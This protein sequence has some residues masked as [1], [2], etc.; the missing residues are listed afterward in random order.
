[1]E[2][3][4]IAV[5]LAFIALVLSSTIQE[6]AQITEMRKLAWKLNCTEPVCVVSKGQ[7]GVW[8]DKGLLAKTKYEVL[9][10]TVEEALAYLLVTDDAEVRAKF[11][12]QIDEKISEINFDETPSDEL[13]L[14]ANELRYRAEHFPSEYREKFN[15]TKNWL[16]ENGT[17]NFLFVYSHH[18]LD[19]KPKNISRTNLSEASLLM[20][21]IFSAPVNYE[22][23]GPNME[24]TFLMKVV[25]NQIQKETDERK[26]AEQL[27][28]LSLYYV[29]TYPALMVKDSIFSMMAMYAL[30]LALICW[31]S[32]LSY[33]TS[34]GESKSSK[35]QKEYSKKVIL[36]ALLAFLLFPLL[37][38]LSLL[39]PLFPAA[40]YII[41]ILP[42]LLP[43]ISFI[44]SSGMMLKDYGIVK[45][46]LEKFMLA[47]YKEF[48]LVVLASALVTLI[49]IFVILNLQKIFWYMSMSVVSALGVL[50]LFVFL[51]V[52]V[53]AFFPRFVEFISKSSETRSA[54]VRRRIEELA[55]KF[56]YN[57][58]SI[59]ILPSSGSNLANAFQSG[60]IGKNIKIF[61][62]ET[63]LDRRKFKQ[64]EL[65]AIVAHEL[66]HINK[67]HVVKTVF[68]YLVIASSVIALF[69][70]F[71]L[72]V[73]AAN[74]TAL[75]ELLALGGPYIALV[76]A[77]LAT[78]RM[79]RG[80]EFEADSTAAEMGY[81]K[82]LISAL[83]KIDRYNLTPRRVS[84][85]IT[86]FSSHADLGSRIRNLKKIQLKQ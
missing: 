66:A 63:M 86:L 62:F 3:L 35:F 42:I 27:C 36:T 45:K 2:K 24:H 5:A 19:I 32:V 71:S 26:L 44:W 54:K 74:L 70:I 41:F 75:R 61:I 85:F 48:F 22:L 17:R 49:S 6:P 80:F 11:K 59:R 76:I 50:F 4:Q 28:S 69:I 79:M 67:K 31:M 57:V 38:Q 47:R 34:K 14:L 40:I 55:G 10:G 65:E 20:L 7:I 73:E 15:Q 30:P 21:S 53:V 83:R 64:R 72:I 39:S 77:F 8:F 56:G 12:T 29:M 82:E 46:N 18:I 52:F 1:M 25:A 81:G 84:K 78:M 9:N 60:L 23:L 16:A 43:T 33:F 13:L 51:S 37:V 68:G 58:D